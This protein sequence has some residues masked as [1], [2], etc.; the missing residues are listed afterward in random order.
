MDGFSHLFARMVIILPAFLAA[1]SFH[2][3]S[4]ALLATILGDPTP[5]RMGR[6]TLNPLAHIDP[7][8]LLFLL[9]FRIGW[10]KPVIFDPRNFKHPR[11]YAIITALAGP[12]SNFILAIVCFYGLAYFPTQLF[13]A[14][15]TVTLV[16]ILQA[17]AYVNIMLGVF[18]ILPIPPLDGS[19]IITALLMNRYPHVVMF[20]YRYSIFFLIGLFLL[21]Q[22]RM[23]L[24]SL[25]SIVEQY[26]KM[27]V[28]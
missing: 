23:I 20:L 9:I 1:L 4:H 10:A 6:V 17:T 11:L 2:E 15:V 12:I 21:P 8:G 3:F 5:K 27:L 13:S 18:N 28:I 16:Q 7:M 14:A 25:I 19:H 26:L 24:I 22:T